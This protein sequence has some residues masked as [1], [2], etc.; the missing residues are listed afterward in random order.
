MGRVPRMLVALLLVAFVAAIS[1]VPLMVSAAMPLAPDGMTQMAVCVDCGADE[2]EDASDCLAECAQLQLA[3]LASPAVG[4][5][6][7]A[8][9]DLLPVP[10]LVGRTGQPSPEPPRAA[11]AS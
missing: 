1:A 9:A 11:A 5:A 2:G 4:M 8:C 7:A 10:M 6:A 3:V